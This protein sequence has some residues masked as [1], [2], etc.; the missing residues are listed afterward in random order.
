MYNLIFRRKPKQIKKI[1]IEINEFIAT[2]GGAKS[3]VWLQIKADILGL[4]L[5]RLKQ[6]ECGLVGTAMIAAVA[7]KKMESYSQ[8]DSYF[9]QTDAIF[10]PNEKVN[11]YYLEKHEK[12]KKFSQHLSH[13]FNKIS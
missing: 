3:N 10:E 2:G 5:V 13:L 7:T 6:S 1:G 8:A 9:I 11:H 4:P 12:Y